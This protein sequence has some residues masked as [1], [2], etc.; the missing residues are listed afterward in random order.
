MREAIAL[1]G[2]TPIAP[3]SAT[4]SREASAGIK[5]KRVRELKPYRADPAPPLLSLAT[6]DGRSIDLASLRGRVVLLNFWASWC[7]P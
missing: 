5:T 2:S 4:T 6:L 3:G 7:P 1:L